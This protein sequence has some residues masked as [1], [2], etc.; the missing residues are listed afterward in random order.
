MKLK[1]KEFILGIILGGVIFGNLTIFANEALNVF[2]NPFKITVN[3]VYKNIEGYNINGSTYFKLR[4][5]GNEV[6]FNVDFKEDIIMINTDENAETNI[7]SQ[8]ILYN[9]ITIDGTEYITPIDVDYIVSNYFSNWVFAY[10]VNENSTWIKDGVSYCYLNKT[11][12]NDKSIAEYKITCKF[13]NGK[14]YLSREVFENEILGRIEK[15]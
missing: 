8:D 9:Y 3:G 2:L 14:P 15:E 10:T 7:S 11:D 13:I 1:H 12:G 5:I 6:G 4:D